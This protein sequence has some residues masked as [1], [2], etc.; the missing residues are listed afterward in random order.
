MPDPTGAPE[1][2]EHTSSPSPVRGL[3]VYDEVA[4]EF[5]TVTDVWPTGL[6]FLRPIGGGLEWQARRETIRPA[7]ASEVLARRVREERASRVTP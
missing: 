3:R 7:L 5:G 1:G 4:D 2:A 6:V